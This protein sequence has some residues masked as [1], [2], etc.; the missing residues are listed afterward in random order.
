MIFP[1]NPIAFLAPATFTDVGVEFKPA[2]IKVYY[3]QADDGPADLQIKSI[4]SCGTSSG[5]IDP[6]WWDLKEE[7]KVGRL[8]IINVAF[9]GA[10]F[11]EKIGND[12]LNN[13]DTPDSLYDAFIS[14][15]T[16]EIVV[17][18]KLDPT[19]DFASLFLDLSHGL[20]STIAPNG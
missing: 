1:D 2:S 5:P 19:D 8:R 11:A 13:V 12:R 17:K 7:G 16:L 15:A 10:S 6:N 20:P 9:K 3:W 4:T 14:R 18:R